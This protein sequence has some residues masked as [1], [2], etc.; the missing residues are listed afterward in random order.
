[1]WIRLLE[2]RFGI[3]YSR[4]PM[5][6]EV[7]AEIMIRIYYWIPLFMCC[8]DQLMKRESLATV[9]VLEEGLAAAT[10]I[11]FLFV[12]IP[13]LTSTMDHFPLCVCQV[14]ESGD[15]DSGSVGPLPPDVCVLANADD[16][17]VQTEAQFGGE[18]VEYD[19]EVDIQPSPAITLDTASRL[20]LTH[21]SEPSDTG[22]VEGETI[23]Q[24]SVDFNSTAFSK[25]FS[26]SLTIFLTS[27]MI[28]ITVMD[29]LG[30]VLVIVSILKNKKLRNAG[31]IFVISLSL[32]DLI[33]GVYSY[34]LVS[35]ATLHNKWILGDT[36]CK[37]S[38][39]IH[40]LSFF[41]SVYS[42][43]GIAMNR[44]CCI[45]HS[46]KYDKLY[47]MKNTYCYVFIT[48]TFS[49]ILLIPT[50]SFDVLQYDE[51][52]H[53]C[54]FIFT[55]NP[56][57]TSSLAVLHFIIPVI[58]V[59]FCY[60]RIWVLVIQ[61]KYRVRQENKQKLKPAEVR[62]FLTM[63]AVF[64]LFAVCWSPFSIP[65]LIMGLNPTGMASELPS[66]LYMFGYFTASFNNCLNGIV[67]GVLNQ[68]FRDEY[69]RILLSLCAFAS[70]I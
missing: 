3:S 37:I 51:R 49:F 53:F 39:M 60:S 20:T 13:W 21:S 25:S 7:A 6:L 23:D 41:V 8:A 28:F 69:K 50:I 61:V 40:T 4:M 31:N 52:V 15:Y 36:Q 34:P 45:C 55:V 35:V 68:N 9:T 42:I 33:V 43:M 1:M 67:Y 38:A 2:R 70:S 12:K 24:G 27:V 30:N 66:W 14:Q 47:S 26:K 10:E 29:V 46:L 58:I 63:F 11:F 32:G 44:Y 62:N 56:S 22:Q 57:L 65:A 19:S 54:A 59:I 18:E 5:Q 48:W 64:V 16:D 17:G